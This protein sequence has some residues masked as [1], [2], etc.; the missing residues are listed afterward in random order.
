LQ[1]KFKSEYEPGEG[2]ATL[3]PH[4]AWKLSGKSGKY[5]GK[6]ENIWANLKM[7]TFFR[8]HTNPMR[9][10]W[11]AFSGL[12]LENT[13]LKVAYFPSTVHSSS[14]DKFNYCKI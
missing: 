12:F 3:L 5:P 2:G 10:K 6:F 8:D 7:K 9:K 13:K 14:Q 11:E 4:P 1:P